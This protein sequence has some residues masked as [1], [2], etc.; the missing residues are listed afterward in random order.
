MVSSDIIVIT[1]IPHFV[2]FGRFIKSNL[3]DTQTAL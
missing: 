2:K 1:Y 3:S